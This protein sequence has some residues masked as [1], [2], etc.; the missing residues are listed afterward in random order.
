M[1]QNGKE[2]MN[3]EYFMGSVKQRVPMVRKTHPIFIT[4]QSLGFRSFRGI[5]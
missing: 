4:Y 3:D 5:N 1:H 2:A